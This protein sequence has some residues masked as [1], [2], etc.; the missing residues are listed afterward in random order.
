[1]AEKRSAWQ[2]IVS[3][4]LL[5]LAAGALLISACS[6]SNKPVE[7]TSTTL[8]PLAGKP[9]NFDVVE[10][11]QAAHRLYAADRADTGIDVFDT[12]SAPAQ[13]LLT[14]PLPAAP[15]GLAIAPRL[16]RLYVGAANG[17]VLFIDISS[18]SA[19]FN[20]VVK[21]VPTGGK[22]ADLIDYAAGPQLV[23]ASTGIEGTIA[24]IDANTGE[25]KRSFKVGF[26][27]E[28]PRFNPA[29][30]LLYVTSPD[31]DGLFPID[32]KTGTVK[33]RVTLGGCLPAGM[34][35]NGHSQ[36]LIACRNAV[37][38]WD[39]LKAV[40]A[41]FDQVVGGDVVTYN[42]TADRFFVAAPAK[43]GPSAVGVFGGNPI[44]YIAA[45]SLPGPA[46]AAGY[47][48][49]NHVVYAP[50]GRVGYVGLASFHPPASEV[51]VYPSVASMGSLAGVVVVILLLFVLV[52]RG[53]DP[54]LRVEPEPRPRRSR[55]TSA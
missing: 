54:I 14:I 7:V 11:D 45:V 23:F 35:I 4:A 43:T 37:I 1:V 28:Q 27:L 47:D 32:L 15:N 48:E 26:A 25:V 29:D 52:G 50:D 20:K 41:R 16:S 39:L 6:L 49:T 51:F 10:L 42:A 5:P 46:K 9:G 36:V 38:T 33:S 21:E 18:T 3:A 17:S 30:G 19:T 55:S 31:A 53:A 34:A 22:D 40:S 12:T 8:A 13:Y 44:A 24:S 2:Q